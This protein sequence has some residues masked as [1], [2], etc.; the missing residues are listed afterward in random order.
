MYMYYYYYFARKMVFPQPTS[1]SKAQKSWEDASPLHFTPGPAG[2]VPFPAS[3]PLQPQQSRKSHAIGWGR[4]YFQLS[5]PCAVC[6][7]AGALW[8]CS[9]SLGTCSRGSS[10]VEWHLLPSDPLMTLSVSA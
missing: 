9:A 2:T 10:P 7:G 6:A 1:E 3:Y 8:G 4:R 5:L